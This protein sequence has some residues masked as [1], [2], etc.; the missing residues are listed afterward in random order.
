MMKGRWGLCC[1]WGRVCT[2]RWT[3]L[4]GDSA[5]LAWKTT[6]AQGQGKANRSASSLPLHQY[7]YTQYR[8]W[9][10][11][12]S[13]CILFSGLWNCLSCSSLSL[14]LLMKDIFSFAESRGVQD[15]PYH[16]HHSDPGLALIGVNH[17]PLT[18]CQ[19]NNLTFKWKEYSKVYSLARSQRGLYLCSCHQSRLWNTSPAGYGVFEMDFPIDWSENA[20]T[21]TLL[22]ESL[23]GG[24]G[25]GLYQN[26]NVVCVSILAFGWKQG[27]HIPSIW[28][29]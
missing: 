8:T 24:F 14:L 10:A 27:S 11:H 1:R 25:D 16:L 6:A 29:T 12:G 3:S 19:F 20:R 2:Y 21:I 9:S 22:M 7:L 13:V 5:G 4:K 28:Q 26:L 23:I 18:N 15:N 17:N